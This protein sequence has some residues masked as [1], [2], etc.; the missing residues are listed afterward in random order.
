MA[1]ILVP[2]SSALSR[3]WA[4]PI[5]SRPARKQKERSNVAS[6]P[7]QKRLLA[8]LAYE[9][10]TAYAPAQELLARELTRQNRTICR[11]T[12]LSPDEACAKAQAESVF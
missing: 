1:A 9:K 4:L 5:E 11:T 3:R 2:S 12:G 6:V 7:F 10:I 8:L